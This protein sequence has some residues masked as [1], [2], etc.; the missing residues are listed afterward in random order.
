MQSRIHVRQRNV[1]D[2]DI[3]LLSVSPPSSKQ[4]LTSTIFQETHVA[5]FS[6][7]LDGIGLDILGED[8]VKPRGVLDLDFTVVGHDGRCCR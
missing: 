4:T 2:F 1:P 8:W 3:V 5:P 6:E 7:Q